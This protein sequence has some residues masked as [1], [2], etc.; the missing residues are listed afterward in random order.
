MASKNSSDQQD[1]IYSSARVYQDTIDRVKNFSLDKSETFD[2]TVN[3]IIDMIE[4]KD[5]GIFQ[6][7]MRVAVCQYC[8]YNWLMT[9]KQ[10]IKKIKC[11]RC[12]RRNK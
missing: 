3:R 7:Q 5:V 4:N 11:P 8:S 9:D 1:K 12:K 6:I 10:D 2:S